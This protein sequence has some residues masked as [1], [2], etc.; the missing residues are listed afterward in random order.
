MARLL[1][2]RDGNMSVRSDLED[3]PRRRLR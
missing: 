1:Y 2:E 3:L